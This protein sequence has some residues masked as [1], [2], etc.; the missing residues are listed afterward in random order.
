M[1]S[2][3]VLDQ[4]RTGHT[5]T[6][7]GSKDIQ[8]E[9][10]ALSMELAHL[11]T[12]IRDLSARRAEI[13]ESIEI[14]QALVAPVRRIPDDILRDIFLACLPTH[15]NAVMSTREAPLILCRI[16][17]TWRALASAT[18]QIWASLHIHID[19]TVANEGRTRATVQW[20]ERAAACPLALSICGNSVAA[21]D[22][23]P[24]ATD[25]VHLYHSLL[26][27]TLVQSAPRWRDIS[28][29][30]LPRS[31][32]RK[33]YDSSA[34]LLRA[35]RIRDKA[36]VVEWHSC[37]VSTVR[38]LILQVTLRP[39]DTLLL[40][41]LSQVTHLSISSSGPWGPGI[42]P[43]PLALGILEYLTQLVSL[44]IAMSILQLPNG[45]TSLPVL[46]SLC[47]RVLHSE[48]A[49]LLEYLV[50]PAF[51]HFSVD[52]LMMSGPTASVW[53]T[54]G[55]RSAL[56]RTFEFGFSTF[57][58]EA[59][60]ETL[61]SMPS[62]SNLVILDIGW[63]S[64]PHTVLP[65]TDFI[66]TLLSEPAHTNPCSSLTGLD[67]GIPICE[68]RTTPQIFIFAG[69]GGPVPSSMTSY[70]QFR[71][72]IRNFPRPPVEKRPS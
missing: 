48:V 45:T 49:P 18:P 28:L 12:L 21:L 15:R 32:F 44:K 64:S 65:D 37:L 43:S 16:C 14:K 66:L 30:D 54:L 40:P 22:L 42:V 29:S 71:T 72:L 5:P 27:D 3:S 33:L 67:K 59:L 31:Y 17:S 24:D 61:Q 7:A 41:R 55:E 6:A 69:F 1:P 10:A 47:L 11:E 35:L 53:T 13:Q 46:E 2:E 52:P 26:L 62:L 20:L 58:R 9:I 63:H 68:I 51:L 34:P 19:F 39:Q 8:S 38:I 57:T 60:R 70:Y 36:E 4:L 23:D 25:S 56:L 50:M